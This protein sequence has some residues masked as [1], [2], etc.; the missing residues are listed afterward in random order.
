MIETLLTR[1]ERLYS[2]LSLRT[3]ELECKVPLHSVLLPLLVRCQ[4]IEALLV[5]MIERGLDQG[6]ANLRMRCRY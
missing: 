2:D 3:I 5:A 4:R 1:I 6:G